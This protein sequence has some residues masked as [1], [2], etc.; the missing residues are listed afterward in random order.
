MFTERNPNER[1][2]DEAKLQREK[3]AR[4]GERAHR[5]GNY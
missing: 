1:R 5:E 3:I 4:E 2:T